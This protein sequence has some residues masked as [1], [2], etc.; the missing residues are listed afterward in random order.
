MDFS[1][2]LT[3]CNVKSKHILLNFLHDMETKMWKKKKN[4]KEAKYRII[5]SSL[6]KFSPQRDLITL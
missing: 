3:V 4:I 6:G 5:Q 2:F 1:L